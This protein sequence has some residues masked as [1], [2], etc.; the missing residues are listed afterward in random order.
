MSVWVPAPAVAGLK[1]L[2][3][4]PGPDQEPG[5]LL[6]V[7]FSAVDAAVVQKGPMGVSVGVTGTLFVT[8]TVTVMVY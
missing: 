7:V 6:C 2:P 5:I 1:E 4:T 8:V 3:D